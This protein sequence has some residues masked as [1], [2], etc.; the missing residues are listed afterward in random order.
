M[1]LVRRLAGLMLAM[2]LALSVVP[3]FAQDTDDTSEDPLEDL[4]EFEG[5]QHGV[6]R[7]WSIDFAAM[8]ETTPT[9]EGDDPFEDMS[10]IFLIGGFV[11]EFDEDG[12]AEDAFTKF[13]DLSDEELASDLADDETATIKREELDDLGDQAMAFTITTDEEEFGGTYRYVIA[14]DGHY[15]LLAIAAGTTE[16]DAAVADEFASAMVDNLDDQS[17]PGEFDEEGGSTGGL[18]DIFP[19]DDDEMFEGLVPLGDEVLYP[20][21]E[22]EES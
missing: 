19:S 17:G 20:E 14:Q 5:I 3:A 2:L 18:W 10:G 12:N 8:M 1:T 16:E 7:S 15:L 4:S 6:S 13:Q 9:G 21:A 22:D 11:L